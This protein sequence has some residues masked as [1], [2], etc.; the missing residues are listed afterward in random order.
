MHYDRHAFATSPDLDTIKPK[1]AY[2]QFIDIMGNDYGRELSVGDRQGMVSVYGAGPTISNVVTNTNDS[3]VGGLRASIFY[4]ID[5]PNTTVTFNIPTN[6]PG[7]A[8][9]VYTIK[10]SDVMTT[11][12]P[13]TTVDGSIQPNGNQKGPSIVIDGSQWPAPSYTMPGLL[14]NEANC[15]VKSVTIMNGSDDGIQIKGSGATGNTIAVATSG[16]TPSEQRRPRM[17]SQASVSRTVRMAIR[18]VEQPPPFAM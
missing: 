8:N 16:P 2:L 17:L 15:T 13:G 14:L 12:G 3:G 18:L 5:H 11:L 7:H 6:D 1:T 10:P 9:N 4:A